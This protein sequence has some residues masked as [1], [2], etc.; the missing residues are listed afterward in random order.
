MDFQTLF[1][2]KE[3]YPA[4]PTA[5]VDPKGIFQRPGTCFFVKENCWK[6]HHLPA[7]FGA[8]SAGRSELRQR[9]YWAFWRDVPGSRQRILSE[10]YPA[11]FEKT[12][13][14]GTE[15]NIPLQSVVMQ[16]E[17]LFDG[18][19]SEGALLD[20]FDTPFGHLARE[21]EARLK[22]KNADRPLD[23]RSN[24]TQVIH[25]SAGRI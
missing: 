24:S 1:K 14:P 11:L 8:V 12:P 3:E 15:F 7:L 10:L 5:K 20:E 17:D 18:L 9:R 6:A 19:S 13:N 23:A 2:R 4:P 16:L 22:D 21:D 25:A